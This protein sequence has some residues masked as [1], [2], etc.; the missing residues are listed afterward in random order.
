MTFLVDNL[1]VAIKT[2]NDVNHACVTGKLCVK[3]GPSFSGG[4][5]GRVL[6]IV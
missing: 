3:S 5:G 1:L 6:A 2:V 4:G